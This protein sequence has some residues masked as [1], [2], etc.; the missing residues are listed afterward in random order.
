MKKK[1]Q[2]KS[3]LVEVFLSAFSVYWLF[4]LLILKFF[5]YTRLKS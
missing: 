5:F 2:K 4:I 1:V 3:Q